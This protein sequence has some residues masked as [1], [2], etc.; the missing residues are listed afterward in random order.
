VDPRFRARRIAVL[1]AAGRRRLWW[2]VGVAAV[3]VVAGG[4]WF[5][6]RTSLLDVDDIEVDGATVTS[7]AD[8]TAALA[9]DPGTPMLDVDPGSLAERVEALPLVAEASV[10]RHW[11][12]RLVVEVTERAP[13]A[14][15][16]TAPDT[17]VEVDAGGRVLGPAPDGSPLPRLSGIH[18]AEEPGTFLDDDSEAPL[19]LVELA[20]GTLDVAGAYRSGGELWLRLDTGLGIKVGTAEDLGIKVV[21]AAALLEHLST[22]PDPDAER[23]LPALAGPSGGGILELDVSVP[24]APVA[25]TARSVAGL[26]D[27]E[28]PPAEVESERMDVVAVAP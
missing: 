1:R 26:A 9:L 22:P 6:T 24:T 4:A 5:V 16:M 23:Q 3:V 27:E 8:I 19:R 15:A 12:N 13:L 21:A 14:L 17:W 20:Q 10:S 25:R 11:P 18:A 28:P 2:L 7:A